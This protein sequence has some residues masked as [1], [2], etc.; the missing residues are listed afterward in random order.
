MGLLIYPLSIFPLECLQAGRLRR[1]SSSNQ[2]KQKLWLK[3]LNSVIKFQ[4]LRM[5]T[6][7]FY[8]LKSSP[9]RGSERRGCKNL[10]LFLVVEQEAV[11]G[12]S[13]LFCA[14]LVRFF[15]FDSFG[16]FTWQS[17][18]GVCGPGPR[19]RRNVSVAPNKRKQRIV[20]L[21]RNQPQSE[22]ID[23]NPSL[24]T[25][26]QIGMPAALKALPE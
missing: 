8:R 15:F 4:S 20:Y 14:V 10:G 7:D 3:F 2:G 13:F 23:E 6:C 16:N 5:L 11:Y 18:K 25:G 22:N 26:L 21:R 24:I 1:L 12:L 17:V 9:K 19:T